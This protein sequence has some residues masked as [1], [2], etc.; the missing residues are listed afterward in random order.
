MALTQK[1]EVDK[2]E[3][4]GKWKNIQVRTASW[5]EDGEG[6][7]IGGKQYHRHVIA[8]NDDYSDESPEVQ[9][10]ASAV[11]TQELINAYLSHINGDEGPVEPS[12][13]AVPSQITALQGMM[14]IDAAGLADAFEAWANDPERTFAEKAYIQKADVWK[15]AD[16][17]LITG[18]AALGLTDEQVD[19]MFIAAKAM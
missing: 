16:P 11:H 2:I 3:V 5:V 19:E 12:E 6:N 15:R 13:P 14:A 7:E 9:A 10:I 1:T 18:A 4:V 17:V 8:P